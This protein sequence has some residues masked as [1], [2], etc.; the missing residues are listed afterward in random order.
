MPFFGHFH[1]SL[2]RKDENLPQQEYLQMEEYDVHQK[3]IIH[4]PLC[5]YSY[6]HW[7][8]WFFYF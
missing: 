5:H 2:F 4:E 3:E 8:G 6:S 7:L 1:F